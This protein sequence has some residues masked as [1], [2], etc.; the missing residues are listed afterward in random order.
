M[1]HTDASELGCGAVL[2]QEQ[3]NE[4]RVIAYASRTLSSSERNYPAHKLEFLAL[5]WVVTDQFHEYLYGGEF[6]VY[7][8]NNP[9]TYIL[10]TAKLDVTGQRWVARLADYNFNLHYRSGKCNVDADALSRIPW[11]KRYD[12]LIDESTMKAIINI[13][14][15]TNHN[16][17]AV[18]FSSAL[19]HEI[20]L[21]AGKITPSKMTNREWV[22]EQMSDPV[23]GEVRKHLIDGTL[24]KI[25][26]TTEDSEA[27]KKLLKHRNQ[28]VLRNNL[29]YH[30]ISNNSGNSMMQFVLPSKFRER[31]LEACH[32]EI[33]HSGF[34][35]SI[36][37]L[38]DRFFWPSMGIDMEKKIKNCDWCLCFKAVPQKTS[39]CPL[40]VTHPLELIHMDYLK[41]ESNQSDKDVYIL[42][43]TDHFTRFAQAFISPNETAPVVAKTLWDQYFMKYGIPEK[44]ISDQGRNF[45]SKL[46]AELCNLGRIQKLHTSP[47][48]PQT[49]GQCEC[50]NS[51]LISMIGTLPPTQKE[52]GRHR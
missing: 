46:I 26:C 32:D 48:R 45:E 18:E 33:G 49:N 12:K 51:T 5:K 30:K 35:R 31:T 42:I 15:V 21:G 25:K 22:E 52:I 37:L 40:E 8:D 17:T 47:Y 34:E 4:K 50:F 9:L 36:D 29:V 39:L 2:Y 19:Q 10:T 20:N 6:E 24:H 27:L 1:L 16:N 7:T 44:I 14:T 23:I 43:V 28:L 11:T 3:D 38:R 13:G 41:I